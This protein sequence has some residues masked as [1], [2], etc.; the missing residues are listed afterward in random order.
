MPPLRVDHDDDNHTIPGM[1]IR[2]GDSRI[3]DTSVEEPQVDSI[4]DDRGYWGRNCTTAD[5][6]FFKHLFRYYKVDATVAN[7]DGVAAS[8]RRILV[9]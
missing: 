8:S 5:M 9:P 6:D 1:H 4:F 2:K 7:A 3:E